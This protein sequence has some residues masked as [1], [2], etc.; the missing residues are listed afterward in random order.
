MLLA[1]L[2]RN[3]VL[4]DDICSCDP[5][6]VGETVDIFSLQ[7]WTKHLAAIPAFPTFNLLGDRPVV[8]MND[9]IDFVARQIGLLEQTPISSVLILFLSRQLFDSTDVGFEF[10][11]HIP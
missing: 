3:K 8:L 9:G 11:V 4:H 2:I 6:A 10:H 7:Q 1:I 5:Q